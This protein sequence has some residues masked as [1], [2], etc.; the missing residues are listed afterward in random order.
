MFRRR[1]LAVLAT[2][3]A[4]AH[5]PAA[6][7]E[8]PLV[9][10][11]EAERAFAAAAGP[12]GV[13]DSFLRF[14]A[15]DGV[16]FRPGPV[17]GRQALESGPAP[18]IALSWYPVYARVSA[19]GDL[20]FTTGPYQA[21]PGPAAAPTGHGHFVTV[22]R[23][24]P[25]GWRFV[26]DLGTPHAELD[27]KLPPWERP[28][29]ARPPSM[30]PVADEEEARES[31]LAADRAFAGAA[32]AEGLGA[33]ITRFGDDEVRLHRAGAFPALGR[34]AAAALA[35]RDARRYSAEPGQAHV[36]RAGDFGYVIGEYRLADAGGN[37]RGESGWY[38]RIWVRRP[39]GPWRL[40]LDVV[41]PRPPEREE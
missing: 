21:R 24:G 38:E 22:W 15:D 4:C 23:R 30:A 1:S 32:Q 20:G 3:T 29:D 18:T 36:S 25:E 7:T 34:Q 35:G 33:A 41:I 6:R 27:P 11:V 17:N 2:V 19:S 5:A 13:R 26:S 12:L 16:L 28:A 37:G 10:M 8:D 9:S 39:G 40:A 31:L 14:I